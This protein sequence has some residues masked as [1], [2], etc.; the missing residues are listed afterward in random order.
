MPPEGFEPTISAGERPQAYAL[1]R[2][3]TGTAPRPLYRRKS[4]PPPPRFLLK[5]R[6][7]GLHNRS[8]Q[9]AED[10]NLLPLSAFEPRIA[11]RWT[12]SIP[13]TSV[14]LGN[15]SY[16]SKIVARMITN[17]QIKPQIKLETEN[18]TAVRSV[19]NKRQIYEKRTGR[20]SRRSVLRFLEL[21]SLRKTPLFITVLTT[22]RQLSL[23]RASEIQFV[24][25]RS[26]FSKNYFNLFPNYAQAF[27][28]VSYLQVSETPHT[29]LFS[30]IRATCPTHLIL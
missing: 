9:F 19:I 3:A 24:A 25:P 26:Y 21:S 6:R 14:L 27:Q 23:S 5:K 12:V 18:F 2:A 13:T 4:P 29:F 10:K 17:H 7:G 20:I 30:T 16:C 15:A 8:G 1:E 22:A 11:G 28:I